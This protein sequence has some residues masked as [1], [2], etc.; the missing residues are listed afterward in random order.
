MSDIH[1]LPDVETAMSEASEWI[2]RLQAEDVR[3]EDRV[4]FEAW[5][6]A[7]PRNGRAYAELMGTWSRF[8]AAGRT[9]RAVSFGNA[10]QG[11]TRARRRR[12]FLSM[13]AAAIVA[14]VALGWWW[15]HQP[16][17]SF[18]TGI[19]EHASIALPDGSRLELNSNSAVRVDYSD[20]AR[21][22]HLAR[23]EAFFTVAHAPERPF[24][25]VADRTWV[26]AVGTAFNVYRREDGVRVT[27]SEGRV[28]VATVASRGAPSDAVLERVPASLLGAGQQA[29]MQ[30]THASVRALPA[31]EVHREVSWRSGTVYFED[32]PLDEVIDEI[33]R[34]TPLRIEVGPRART[35]T[36]GGT[37]QT[38]PQGAEML[39]AMLKEG[40]GLE[41][42]R[43]GKQRVYVD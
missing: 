35:M 22:I 40:L 38:N 33:S 41:V 36:V 11:A 31:P 28:K 17:S 4:R 9:V 43:D 19:G 1:R 10:M 16:P 24:W 27:V 6:T 5:R 8:T 7:H 34:Y 37:F 26:R 18:E 42:R 25:V 32:R 30:G 20:A 39:L 13:A 12:G 3:V 21:V 23:G 14:V 15:Q 29:E 2:A